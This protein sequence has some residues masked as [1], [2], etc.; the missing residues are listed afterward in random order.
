MCD[1]NGFPHSF[2]GRM[3]VARRQI[4]RLTVIARL[5]VTVQTDGHDGGNEAE[6]PQQSEKGRLEFMQATG[7]SRSPFAGS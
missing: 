6:T 4:C 7:R 1:G 5:V 3:V 2:H